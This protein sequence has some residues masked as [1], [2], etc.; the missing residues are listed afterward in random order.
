MLGIMWAVM[1]GGGI[2]T[3]LFPCMF[4]VENGLA[5]ALIIAILATS[6]GL[7]LLIV[8]D[9]NNPFRGDVHIQPD[10]F[11]LVLEQFGK[12]AG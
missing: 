2:L 3:V 9:L 4:G 8:Y 12:P 11:R 10:G 7:M 6:I 5:H 1:I